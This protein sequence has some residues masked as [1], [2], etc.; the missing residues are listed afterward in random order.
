MLAIYQNTNGYEWVRKVFIVATI[1]ANTL[2]WLLVLYFP[3]W[4]FEELSQGKSKA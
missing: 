4:K 1:Y 2:Y 3:E